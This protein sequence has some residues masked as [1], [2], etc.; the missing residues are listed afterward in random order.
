MTSDDNSNNTAS[1]RLTAF[2]DAALRNGA[3]PPS[4]ITWC[5]GSSAHQASLIL[6]QRLSKILDA[7]PWLAGRIVQREDGTNVLE[8]HQTIPDAAVATSRIFRVIDESS[9]TSLNLSKTTP[10]GKVGRTLADA[11]L[12]L[13]FAHDPNKPLLLVSVIAVDASYFALVVSLSHVIGDGHSFYSIYNMLTSAKTDDDEF[14]ALDANRIDIQMTQVNEAMGE[15]QAGLLS[16]G[17]FLLAA[18]RGVLTALILGLFS[19][20]YKVET[21]CWLVD[22]EKMKQVKK[23]ACSSTTETNVDF[24]STNDVLTSW[25]FRNSNCQHGMMAINL[26]NRLGENFANDGMAGNYENLLYYRIPQ[27]CSTAVSIRQSLALL[28]RTGA[29]PTTLELATGDFAIVSNWASF[30]A[31]SF[32]LGEGCREEGHLPIYDS[33]RAPTSIAMAFIFRYTSSGQLGVL[34]LGT[35]DQLAGLEKAH[36]VSYKAIECHF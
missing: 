23:E 4:S 22:E 5:A 2:E 30:S 24:V 27:D 14:V 25:F 32:S 28:E 34:V 36:F 21:R 15:W 1:T 8:Y 6:Q 7:N 16:S 18:V 13:R 17:G 9:S 31:P 20:K 33:S 3:N 29:P 12:L 19:N 10:F 26:R 11:G 35:R